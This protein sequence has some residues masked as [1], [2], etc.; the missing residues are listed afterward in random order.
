MARTNR[1]EIAQSDEIRVQ[2]QEAKVLK[3]ASSF[4]MKNRVERLLFEYTPSEQVSVI[5]CLDN[6]ASLDYFPE[7]VE[8]L[9]RFQKCPSPYREQLLFLLARTDS[10]FKGYLSSIEG[11]Y[12]TCIKPIS[13]GAINQGCSHVLKT[14]KAINELA[15]T[16]KTNQVRKPVL[17]ETT[18]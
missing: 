1:Q 15:G 2:K 6:A 8:V 11:I 14:M 10:E 18:G 13:V 9:E 16:L 5:N 7:T 3:T 17:E 12:D 4:R